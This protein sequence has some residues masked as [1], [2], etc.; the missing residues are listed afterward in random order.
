MTRY[1]NAVEMRD[2]SKHYGDFSI[3]NVN[4]TVPKGYIVGLVGRNGAGKSTVI[5]MLTGGA[6]PDSG[7]IYVLGKSV[8]DKGFD[9]V[10]E[11]IGVVFDYSGYPPALTARDIGKIMK[12]IYKR[13]DGTRY[14][15]YLERFGVPQ[16]KKF[17]E[18]SQG[19]KMKLSIAV[20]MSHGARLLIL[21][22]ATNGL[23]PVARDEAV[24][25]F[26]EYTRNPENSVLITTHIV[27][28]LEKICDYIAVISDGKIVLGGEKD[29]L[30]ERYMIASLSDEEYSELDKRAVVGM[31][32]EKY[33]VSVM[34]DTEIL[35]KAAE[36]FS[37]E[38]ANIEDMLIF[39]SGGRE[40]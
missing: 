36:R 7:E 21:D 26:G 38:K 4:F 30:E 11:D 17:S 33:G 9:G 10:K 18:F 16:D 27:S 31:R 15:E 37:G 19:T 35:G 3:R 8:F 40:E 32:E 29:S 25:M 1:E 14:T 5:N 39:I 20:A 6:K 2:V 28:D 24:R 23:D 34:L 22:E 12:S 13:W